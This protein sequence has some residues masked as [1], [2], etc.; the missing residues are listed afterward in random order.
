MRVG[1][2]DLPRL[3]YEL[4]SAGILLPC[5]P[6]IVRICSPFRQVAEG[7]HRLYADFEIPCQDDFVDFE[8]ELGWPSPLRRLVRPQANFVCDGRVPFNPLPR[9]QCFPMLEW[10]LNW[11][12]STHAHDHLILHAAVVERDGQALLLSA[13]P[14]S[15]KSTLCAGL[16][17]AG[18][19]LLSD[20][21]ALVDL[22]TGRVASI[23]RPI[24]LKNESIEVVRNLGAGVVLSVVCEGTSKGSVAHMRPPRDS[25]M[26]RTE[27]A[28]PAWLV[29]PH[30]QSGAQ[31]AIEPVG[32]AR[33]F[34]EMVRH[35]FNYGLLGVSAFDAL[36]ELVDRCTIYSA[37]YGSLEQ[38]IPALDRLVR[39]DRI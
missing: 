27:P 39:N 9:S 31:L 28:V 7:L 32:K 12:I 20:E 15:G 19:R 1:D 37:Q 33:A 8:V 4:S 21:L 29:F 6:F 23:A 25:V 2:L 17:H 11:V 35:A 3:G 34:M 22:A 5:G 38:I 30:F 10:G 18:W 13:D 14:G 16:V 26:R 36:G 24:S